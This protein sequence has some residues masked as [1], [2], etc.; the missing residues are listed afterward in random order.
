MP[1]ITGASDPPCTVL[2]YVCVHA[3]TR[4]VQLSAAPRIVAHQALLLMEFSRQEECSGLSFPTP[5]DFPGPGIKLPSLASPALAGGFFITNAIWET[6]VFFLDNN[7][8]L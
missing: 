6:H 1:K 5:G 8:Y 2:S 7:T 3:P 4:H